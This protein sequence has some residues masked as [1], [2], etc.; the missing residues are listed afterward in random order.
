MT[1][2]A[3]EKEPAA[4]TAQQQAAHADLASVVGRFADGVRAASAQARQQASAQ[5]ERLKQ[6]AV[7]HPHET[8]TGAF[9]LG[10]LIG[11]SLFRRRR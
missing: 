6:E 5:A 9:G 8:V 1:D 11:K 10:Y 7:A 3:T 4:S 2:K